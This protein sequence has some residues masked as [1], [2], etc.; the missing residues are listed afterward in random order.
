MTKAFSLVFFILLT[1]N[2]LWA[3]SY[4]RQLKEGIELSY[5]FKLNDAS[6]VYDQLIKSN[7]ENPLAYHYKSALYFWK[8][9]SVPDNDDYTQF[10][11]YS[12]IAI[13][14][15]NILLER[16]DPDTETL[17]LIG[18]TYTLRTIAFARK[19]NYLEC[20]WAAQKAN[21]FLEGVIKSDS[22]MYDAYLGLGLFKIF[23]SQVPS[24]FK[25]A[26][27][28][29]GFRA[30]LKLGLEYL[31]LAA[32]KSK[33]NEVESKFYYAFILSE[34]LHDYSESEKILTSLSARYQGNLL[35]S[36]FI[37]VNSIKLKDLESAEKHLKKIQRV[38]NNP[39]PKLL[40]FTNFLLGDVYFYSGDYTKG[41]KYYTEFLAI[42]RESDYKGIAA[43]R[44]GYSYEFLGNRKKAEEFYSKTD[45]GSR[46]IDEDHYA[47]RRGKELASRIVYFDEA[48]VMYA[49]SLQIRGKADSAESVLKSVISTGKVPDM[50]AEAEFQL[51]LLLIRAND[52][53]DVRN[54][55]NSILEKK[56][57]NERW[58]YPYSLYLLAELAVREKDSVSF[59]SLKNK[60]VSF[61]NFDFSSKLEGLFFSLE[62][63]LK[64]SAEI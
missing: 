16:N 29:I 60:A 31:I 25:W 32:E 17:L 55:A 23:L 28:V 51:A 21:S 18:N 7:P 44:L 2:T 9:M 46:S 20:I 33:S 35:F 50:V 39:L 62:Y 47:E 14:K 36:Y 37:A 22:E 59:N 11:K 5:N 30:D 4:T 54:L 56:N 13:E 58:L 1:A 41:I 49:E 38:K 64:N 10:L 3:D 19:E 42:S 53:R 43:L 26:L 48:M 15:I 8:L 57:L 24:S 12:D 61:S 6:K 63:R 45:A 40:A 34:L 27:E 52:L